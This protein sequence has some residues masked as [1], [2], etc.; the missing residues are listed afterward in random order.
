MVYKDINI[1]EGSGNLLHRLWRRL[2]VPYLRLVCLYLLYSLLTKPPEPLSV[3][4][5]GL[6]AIHTQLVGSLR[7]RPAQ[8]GPTIMRNQTCSRRAIK[9]IQLEVLAGLTL[10][11]LPYA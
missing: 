3:S 8:H 2:Q 4:Q 1:L 9:L 5:A 10:N 7:S 6:P 11:S